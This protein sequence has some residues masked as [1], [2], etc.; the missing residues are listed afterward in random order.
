[1]V[2]VLT[3]AREAVPSAGSTAVL[4]STQCE[5]VSSTGKPTSYEHVS[6]GSTAIAEERRHFGA[7]PERSQTRWGLSDGSI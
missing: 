3:A 4:F 1:M 6:A 2:L 7:S 5:H